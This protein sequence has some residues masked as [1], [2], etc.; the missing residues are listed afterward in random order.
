M[1]LEAHELNELAGELDGA[2]ADR[3]A[4]IGRMEGVLQRRLRERRLHLEDLRERLSA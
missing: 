4:L 3:E 2:G 1:R